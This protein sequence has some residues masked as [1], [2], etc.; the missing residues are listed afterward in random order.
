MLT[1]PKQ[2]NKKSSNRKKVMLFVVATILLFFLTIDVFLMGYLKYSFYYAKCGQ[3]PVYDV[4][5]SYHGDFMG[6]DVPGSSAYRIRAVNIYYCTRDQAE[7]DGKLP[8]HYSKE[9][10]Q[11]EKELRLEGKL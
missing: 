11:R 6:Y 2:L 10:Q 4:R 3:A 8:N 7:A 9:G 1:L 5:N